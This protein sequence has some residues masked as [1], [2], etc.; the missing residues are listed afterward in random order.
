[1]SEDRELPILGNMR[2]W[3]LIVAGID[4]DIVGFHAGNSRI[5]TMTPRMDS[6]EVEVVPATQLRGAVATIAALRRERDEL[7]GRLKRA[8]SNAEAAEAE[9]ARLTDG[10]Q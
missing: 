4:D 6:R 2:H 9:L 10:G 1:M 5:H 7:A 3:T 8:S